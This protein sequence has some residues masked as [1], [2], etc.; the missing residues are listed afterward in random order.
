MRT[1]KTVAIL[2]SGKAGTGKTTLS[3][4]LY[5]ILNSMNLTITQTHFAKKLKEAAVDYFNWDYRK[6]EKGRKLLQ[7]LGQVGR[8]YNE[9]LWVDR[10]IEDTKSETFYP[11]N[12]LLIDDWRFRNELERFRQDN[13]FDV[14]PLRITGRNSTIENEELANE[15]SEIDLDKPDSSYWYIDNSGTIEELTSAA[16]KIAEEI[17][18]LYIIE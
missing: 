17:D 1:R 7:R 15:I 4:L 12:F 9:T 3:N 18:K 10:V 16:F 13:F 11:V 5:N 8:E 6:D 2:I 14:V